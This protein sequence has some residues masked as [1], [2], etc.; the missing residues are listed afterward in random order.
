MWEDEDPG[1]DSTWNRIFS[2][3]QGQPQ[4]GVESRNSFGRRLRIKPTN[5]AGPRLSHF[6]VPRALSHT[7]F[8]FLPT[9]L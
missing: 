5:S 9:T 2:S 6:T 7:F 8:Q 4:S 3:I 1:W